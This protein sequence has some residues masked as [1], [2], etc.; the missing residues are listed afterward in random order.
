[1]AYRATKT[2]PITIK[3]LISR[4]LKVAP[5]GTVGIPALWQGSLPSEG[6]W[7]QRFSHWFF[8]LSTLCPTEDGWIFSRS[9][10]GNPIQVD[11]L[12]KQ[13]NF[14]GLSDQLVPRP[15]FPS[16]YCT[17]SNLSGFPYFS[18]ADSFSPLFYWFFRLPMRFSG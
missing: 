13:Q 10:A 18:S 17:P 15:T 1:M 4:S 8:R 6:G 12:K 14:R 5:T 16:R 2:Q 9:A 11:N 3:F 7:A